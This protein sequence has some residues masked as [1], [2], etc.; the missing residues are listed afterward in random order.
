MVVRTAATLDEFNCAN[1]RSC[2]GG[3]R[4]NACDACVQQNIQIGAGQI[5]R[6]EIRRRR[7]TPLPVLDSQL[8]PA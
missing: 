4:E 2:A 8:L 7:A 5:L 6:G 3:S 1:A